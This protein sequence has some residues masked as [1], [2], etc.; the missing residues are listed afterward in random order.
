MADIGLKYMAGAK[1]ATEPENAMPTYE[2]GMVIGKMVQINLAVK[3]AEGKLYA[4]D[5]L[6]EYVSE[7]SE[8]DLTAEVDNITL[9]KQATMYGATYTDDELMHNA[10]DQAPNMGVGGVQPLRVGSVKKFRTWFFAKARAALPDWKGNTR[11]DSISFGTQ[12]IKMKIT[13][14]NYGAWYRVKEF[15]SYVAAK[16]HIDTL[17]GVGVWHKISVQVNGASTG[18]GATPIGTGYAAAGGTYELT[19]AGTPTALYDNG[20]ESQASI[21]GGKY[22]LSSV[23]E[24]HNIAVIF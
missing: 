13:S 15:D 21:S 10:E 16:A 6:A 18:E 19:I 1:M 17:L 22:T 12:P 7:F 2:P 20:V 5:E 24:D 23:A 8:A 9:D 4:D 14:P 3:N 11:G